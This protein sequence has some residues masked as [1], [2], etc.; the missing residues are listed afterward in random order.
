MLN[1]IKKIV[2]LHQIKKKNSIIASD[3]N[4]ATKFNNKPK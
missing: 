2:L 4:I 3:G 1:F